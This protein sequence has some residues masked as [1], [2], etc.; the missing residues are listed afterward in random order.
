MTYPTDPEFSRVSITSRHATFRSEARNGRTQVRSIGAQRW[1]LTGRYNDL[2]RPEFA[3]I[4]AFVMS[5]EGG[6][7]EFTV[8]PPVISD[9]SGT[10][11]GTTQ[12]LGAHAIGD[13]TITVDGG[14]GTIKAGDFVKFASHDKVYMVTSDLTSATGVLNIQ[15]GLIAAIPDNDVLTYNSVPFKVRL[16]NEVQ[17]WAL[18]GYDRYNFEIDFIEV[19]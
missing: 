5:Q 17:Q 13:T 4:F 6:V 19:L 2:T 14:S 3:P 8:T 18:S 1:A 7:Q 16:E 12:S 11:T 10:R 15:P 9:S